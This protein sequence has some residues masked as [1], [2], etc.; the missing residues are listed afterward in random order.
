MRSCGGG[1]LYR[2][3]QRGDPLLHHIKP[4]VDGEIIWAPAIEGGFVLTTRGGDF[5]L[6]IGQEISIAYLSHSGAM[7]ELHLQETFT[8][9]M[10]TS[11]ASI[12]P[13]P[14]NP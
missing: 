6:D 8:F 12:I 4:V 13:A 2:R 10:L 1:D 14:V 5:E 11:E 9:R 3:E 7:V